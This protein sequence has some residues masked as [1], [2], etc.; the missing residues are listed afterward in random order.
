MQ[1][2][3]NTI[4]RSNALKKAMYK[5]FNLIGALLQFL[6]NVVVFN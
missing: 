3:N 6:Y 1:P 4:Y 5:A 2:T